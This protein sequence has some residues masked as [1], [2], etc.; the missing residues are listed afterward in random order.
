MKIWEAARATSAASTFF[1][2]IKIGRY[3]EEFVDGAIG[4]NNPVRELWT[5]AQDLWPK[6]SLADRIK[7]FVSIG[8]GQPAVKAFGADVI[9]IGKTM[10]EIA[11]DT[12]NTA[13]LFEMEHRDLLREGRYF[14]FNV[15]KGLEDVGLEEAAKLNVV[16]A[17]TR[18][19]I[20]AQDTYVKV[21][22]CAESISSRPRRC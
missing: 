20:R 7:C 22:A 18:R 3:G 2:P 4:A 9:E 15:D 14:R 12:E 11:T 17:T 16:V 1:D 8:T 21:R 10:V 13:R 5:E 6:G 19:Y